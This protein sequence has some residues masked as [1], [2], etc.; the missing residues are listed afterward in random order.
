MFL[1][2]VL[3]WPTAHSAPEVSR[4]RALHPGLDFSFFFLPNK[5]RAPNDTLI[6][7]DQLKRLVSSELLKTSW[8]RTFKVVFK[9]KR[10]KEQ[11]SN[12]HVH[13]CVCGA[14][15]AL[16]VGALLPAGSPA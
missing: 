15:D 9:K 16:T 3:A 4:A 5:S 11:M 2:T 12:V 14:Q 13:S 10:K 8:K 7:I 6:L 1:W